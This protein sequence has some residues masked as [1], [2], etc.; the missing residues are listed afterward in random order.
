MNSKV[1]IMVDLET[2]G[3]RNDATVFQIA[4]ASFD[5][6]TGN[7]KDSIDLKL[8][9]ASVDDLKVDGSTLV[10]WLNTNKE[11]LSDLLNTG[12][13]HELTT[14]KMYGLFYDWMT[15]QLNKNQ[16]HKDIV[17]WGNGILFDNAKLKHGFEE[18]NIPY[19]IHYKNDLDVRTIVA[20]AGDVA[21]LTKA[22]LK[23]SV[24]IDS[25]IEHDAMDDVSF[26]I[27][28]VSRCY[29]ILIDS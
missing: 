27:R 12:A 8:D 9:I 1:N 3:L 24:R 14:F 10:W 17:L 7:I 18:Q 23:D 25:E 21:G 6:K 4:A 29:N 5:L 22:E 19:P 26:Q 11:L 28:L 16:S 2:L 15:N 20:L 13:E